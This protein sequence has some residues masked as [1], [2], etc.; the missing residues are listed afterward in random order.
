MRKASRPSRVLA[1]LNPSHDA[2]TSLPPLKHASSDSY[3]EPAYTASHSSFSCDPLRLPIEQG[4]SSH[5]L[6]YPDA[7]DLSPSGGPIPQTHVSP[8]S[9]DS[10]LSPHEDI[11]S[12]QAGT[13]GPIRVAK[14]HS[15][16]QPPGHIPRPRNAFI[17]YRSWYV[18]QGFLSDV[19]N[20]HRE[21]SRIVGKIW[22]HMSV[23]E[24]AP[25]RVRAEE[26]KV[27]HARLY[28]N[29]KYSPN[30][31]RDAAAAF[32]TSRSA[33]ACS[34][35]ARSR[36]TKGS[37]TLVKK[38]SDAFVSGSRKLSL[39]VGVRKM[40]E[41]L[42][43]E[44]DSEVATETQAHSLAYP[45]SPSGRSSAEL[46]SP[47]SPVY[48]GVTST[49]LAPVSNET[50]GP[51]APGTLG[52]NYEPADDFSLAAC[53]TFTDEFNP[54]S[55]W[56]LPEEQ[57]Y[58][59]DT[60]FKNALKTYC[61]MDAGLGTSMTCD[62]TTDT[63]SFKFPIDSS[64]HS[65]TLYTS[66]TPNYQPAA[67]EPELS[68]FDRIALEGTSA[69]HPGAT[70]FG[71]PAWG[72][73]FTASSSNDAN[74]TLASDSFSN[75]SW[76]QYRDYPTAE[77]GYSASSMSGDGQSDDYGIFSGWCKPGS[78][79]TNDGS[80]TSVITPSSLSRISS[81]PLSLAYPSPTCPPKHSALLYHSWETSYEDMDAYERALGDIN[82][83]I[84]DQRIF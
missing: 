47:A 22:K 34:S 30:S 81:P 46:E 40:D 36:K 37:E 38:R 68:P 78:H 73:L 84:D 41:E 16:R 53:S 67:S 69:G 55:V 5:Q 44:E 76:S 28:P 57:Y 20:D 6:Y 32:P 51:D 25:W 83:E 18:K 58:R 27:E 72:T 52:T 31:R 42:K 24:Q 21:I 10:P 70:S 77:E 71:T 45:A 59:S 74:N 35:T 79:V 15:R 33:P 43:A 23:E 63:S 49:G 61:D 62:D 29:Y 64:L 17:L 80:D 14:S 13:V 26:E 2:P 1:S 82:G 66:T 65:E 7:D 8:S 48:S 56:L 11:N 60:F 4:T 75:F 39:V 54:D 12:F 50:S 9:N 3:N 19:E